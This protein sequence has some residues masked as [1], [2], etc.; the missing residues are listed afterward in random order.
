MTIITLILLAAWTFLW[1]CLG[2][3][4]GEREARKDKKDD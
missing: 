3:L 1:L 2:F 4:L